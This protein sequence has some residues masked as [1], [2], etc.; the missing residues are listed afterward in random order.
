MVAQAFISNPDNKRTVNHKNSIRSDNR[1]ENLEWMT[2]SENIQHWYDF[3]FEIWPKPR[4]W[5]F[6]KDH[7]RSKPLQQLDIY[8]NIIKQWDC[9][10][11]MNRELWYAISSISRVCNG[12]KE[13]AYGYKWRYIDYINTH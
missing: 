7:H 5:K 11:W 13:L 1:V 8:W 9:L 12:K 6:W 2:D 3:W 10:M 4:L